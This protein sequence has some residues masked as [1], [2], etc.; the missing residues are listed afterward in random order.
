MRFFLSSGIKRRNEFKF[1]F[2]KDTE[3][4]ILEL[5]RD[6]GRKRLSFLLTYCIKKFLFRRGFQSNKSREKKNLIKHPY[7]SRNLI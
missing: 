5:N 6:V 3:R 4:C 1:F 7:V 2:F